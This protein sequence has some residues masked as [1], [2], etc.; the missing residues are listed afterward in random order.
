MMYN[1]RMIGTF[2]PL[3]CGIASFSRDMANALEHFTGEVGN[4]RVTAIDDE[5]ASYNIP[6]DMTIDKF[7]PDS[8]REATC[9]IVQRARE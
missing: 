1:I 2:P 3:R 4:I 5:D 8:W 6:V 7:S 9:N